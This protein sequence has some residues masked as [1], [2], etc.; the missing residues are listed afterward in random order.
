[1]PNLFFLFQLTA[2]AIL[3]YIV[4]SIAPLFTLSAAINYAVGAIA[5]GI[6]VYCMK[7][8]IIVLRRQRYC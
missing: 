1:M 2:I 5:F 8:R 6:I 3:S 7:K 4:L